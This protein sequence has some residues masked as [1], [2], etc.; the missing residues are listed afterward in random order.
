LNSSLRGSRSSVARRNPPLTRE[1]A[2][3]V[4]REIDAIFL[5][6]DAADWFI[7]SDRS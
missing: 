4:V 3:F 6:I 2:N 7:L 1:L 5:H